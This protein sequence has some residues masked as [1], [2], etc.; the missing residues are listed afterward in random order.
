M[1]NKLA[2]VFIFVAPTKNYINSSFYPDGIKDELSS[3]TAKSLLEQKHA[4]WG[5]IYD[6][7]HNDF[8]IDLSKVN[9]YKNQSGKPFLDNGICISYSHNIDLVAFAIS[10]NNVGVDVEQIVPERLNDRLKT[11]ILHQSEHDLS[12]GDDDIFNYWTKKEA[13][14]KLQGNLLTFIPKNIKVD[15]YITSSYLLGFDNKRFS[16]SLATEQSI[17]TN[18]VL[19]C[20]VKKF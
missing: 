1:K 11:K 2:E 3:I 15:D 10:K 13:I 17:T 9:V 16:L 6:V 5:L 7:L 4:V 19:N 20:D 12:L 8:G 18:L 14:F